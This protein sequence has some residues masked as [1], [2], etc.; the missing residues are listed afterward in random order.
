MLE[1]IPLDSMPCTIFCDIDGCILKHEWPP[2]V[3][4]I[5]E[6]LEGAFIKFTEW[7]RQGHKIILTTA[8]TSNYRD[9]TIRALNSHRLPF[10]EL[11]MDLPCGRRILINDVKPEE[12]ELQTAIAYNL[13]RNA[14]LLELDWRKAA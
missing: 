5:P 7:N 2:D 4:R 8:R 10:N 6:L 14:G 3:N 13:K 9:V 12:A 1:I 11:L